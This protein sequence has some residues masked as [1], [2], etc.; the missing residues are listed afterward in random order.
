MDL[1]NAGIVVAISLSSILFTELVNWVLIYRTANYQLLKKRAE[2][3]QKKIDQKKV[4]VVAKVVTQGVSKKVEKKEKMAENEMKYVSN[5]LHSV[6]MKST[7]VVMGC[8]IALYSTMSSKFEGV[9]VARIPFVP[10][11]PFRALAHKG[12]AGDDYTD[13]SFAFLYTLSSLGLRSS[14][15][16]LLGT[17]SPRPAITMWEQAEQMSAKRKLL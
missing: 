7:V 14:I 3:L 9:V 15:Q 6:K 8:M 13:C 1:T 4:T 2:A 16:K 5:A 11:G 12:L 10:P 17:A